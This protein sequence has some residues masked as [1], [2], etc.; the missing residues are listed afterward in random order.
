[1]IATTR[2][3]FLTGAI[4]A[5]SYGRILGVTIAS[6]WEPSAQ[7]AAASTCCPF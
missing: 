4:T 5:A 2:R 1:M 3:K 7:A 6:E